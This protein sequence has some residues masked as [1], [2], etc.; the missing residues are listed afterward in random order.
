MELVS[1]DSSD[2][3]KSITEYLNYIGKACVGGFF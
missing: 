2:E 1:F 3:Q